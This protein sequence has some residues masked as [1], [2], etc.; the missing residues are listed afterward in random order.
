MPK[1]NKR[2]ETAVFI[3]EIETFFLELFSRGQLNGTV[4]TCVGQELIPVVLEESLTDKDKVFS[5]HRGHGHF[6]ANGGNFKELILELMGSNDGVSAGIGGSQHIQT[7]SFLSNGIQGGTAPIAV[8]YSYIEK[9]KETSNISVCYI[10][11]GTL[12]EGQFYESL[13]LAR[14]FNSQILFVLENNG[15]AQSTSSKNTLFGDLE[16]RFKGFGIKYFKGDVWNLESLKD[17]S[18]EAVNSA[19][20]GRPSIL[21]VECYRLNSHSK[22]DDNRDPSEVERYKKMDALNKYIEKNKDWYQKFRESS[23][24]KFEKVAREAVF[25]ERD[26]NFL[27]NNAVFNEPVDW[28]IKHFNEDHANRRINEHINMALNELLERE[29]AVL[30]GEDIM[31]TTSETPLDYGGAFKVTKGLSTSHPKLVKNTSISE[32]GLIGFGIGCALNSNPA[33][34]EIMFGDFM[35]LCVDQI[36]QQASKIPTMYGKEVS[37]PLMI[38]TPMGGRRGYGPT[39]SQNIEKMFLFWPNVNVYAVNSLIEFS[40]FYRNVINTNKTGIVIEDKVSYTQTALPTAPNGFDVYESSEV[41]T[42]IKVEPNFSEPNVIIF[43]Y[44]GMLSEILEILPN[45]VDEEVFPQIISPSRLS[46]MNLGI[47]DGIDISSLPSIF[48]EEG[49]KRTSWS[50]EIIS[51]L[52]EEG[53]SFKKIYRISNECIIPCAKDLEEKI[54]PSRHNLLRKI[55]SYNI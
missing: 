22:G 46:P 28:K 18:Q 47:F 51:S 38:R 48:I 15:Y 20:N 40:K 43:T 6:I 36:L 8:G 31:D 9:L 55:K 29:K 44:G 27:G 1:I 24:K 10:G 2:I 3:R 14:I 42:T 12:G 16:K 11:D 23:W 19:R 26:T 49:S 45:L 37:L 7:S 53:S 13:T 41:F 50:S 54:S 30:V 32:A 33:I 4:H 21:E 39:H 5:N 17:I 35:T 25:E 34:V 52:S